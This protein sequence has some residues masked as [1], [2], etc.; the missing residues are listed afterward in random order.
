MTEE[1]ALFPLNTVL[2]PGGVLP[3]RIF[4]ARYVD[5]VGRCMRSST[6]FG[7]VLLDAGEE[8]GAAQQ[9]HGIGTLAEIVDFSR[10]EDGL[11][12]I[13]ALGRRKFRIESTAQQADGL[14]VAQVE[15]LEPEPECAL[16]DDCLVLAELLK[17]ALPQLGALYDHLDKRYDDAAWV[18]SRLV[19]ILPLPLPNKQHCLELADPI[20]R[21]EYLKPMIEVSADGADT[22]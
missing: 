15:W 6:G 7:V 20:E 1:I 14:N 8:A 19:A 2:F 11:L 3:L 12:G 17:H 22:H 4:E 21:L 16:P 13:T 10:L 5:M 18:G 9:V